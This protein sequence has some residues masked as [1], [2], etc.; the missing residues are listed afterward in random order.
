MCSSALMTAEDPAPEEPVMATIGC[1]ADMLLFLPVVYMVCFIPVA[2]ANPKHKSKSANRK[3]G[4]RGQKGYKD[5][6]GFSVLNCD[7]FFET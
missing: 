4:S 5:K 1:S 3:S 7:A 6:A 2:P